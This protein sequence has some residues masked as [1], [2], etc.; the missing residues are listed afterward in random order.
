LRSGDDFGVGSVS[1]AEAYRAARAAFWL[2][3]LLLLRG[4]T[5]RSGGWLARAQRLLDE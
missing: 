1:W 4:D 5:A 2:S 3:L